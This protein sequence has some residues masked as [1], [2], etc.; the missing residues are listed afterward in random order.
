MIRKQWDQTSKK[1][2]HTIQ[3]SVTGQ[4]CSVKQRKPVQEGWARVAGRN[5]DRVPVSASQVG[6]RGYAAA[7]CDQSY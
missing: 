5:E 1:G 3:A 7:V 2:K 6:N 4:R